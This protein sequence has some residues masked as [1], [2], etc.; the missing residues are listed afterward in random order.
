MPPLPPQI[1]KE[2][3]HTHTYIYIYIHII[4]S[5]SVL[6]QGMADVTLKDL[7]HLVITKVNIII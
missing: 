2:K 1:K 5:P 6:A 3:K 4:I 7:S